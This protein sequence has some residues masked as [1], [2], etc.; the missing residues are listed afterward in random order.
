MAMEKRVKATA[1]G[2]IVVIYALRGA[3]SSNT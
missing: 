1:M 2:F 3:E